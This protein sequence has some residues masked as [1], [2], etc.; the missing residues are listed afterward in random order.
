MS[1]DGQYNV[2]SVENTTSPRPHWLPVKEERGE[3]PLTS[4]RSVLVH[5]ASPISTTH[6]VLL[7]SRTDIF[8]VK[9]LF[10][11]CVRGSRLIEKKKKKKK[12]ESTHQLQV[13]GR[14]VDAIS[15]SMVTRKMAIDHQHQV[16]VPAVLPY[17]DRSRIWSRSSSTCWQSVFTGFG[18]FYKGDDHIWRDNLTWTDIGNLEQSCLCFL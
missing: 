5:K 10:S 4:L 1:L 7:L 18:I 14:F 11:S 12:K 17:L 13:G 16:L 3:D 8:T 6:S 15:A 2:K 9:E